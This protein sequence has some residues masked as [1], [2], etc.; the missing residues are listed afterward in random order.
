MASHTVLQLTLP[1]QR[2]TRTSD[3]A[4]GR[5]ESGVQLR[6]MRLQKHPLCPASFRDFAPPVHH[7]LGGYPFEMKRREC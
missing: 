2:P 3:T 7:Q 5:S 4:C 1:L 6:G